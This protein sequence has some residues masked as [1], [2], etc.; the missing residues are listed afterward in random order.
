MTVVK[1]FFQIQVNF[2]I[3]HTRHWPSEN[4]WKFYVCRNKIDFSFI[5]LIAR[6]FANFFLFFF[7]LIRYLQI[8][9][10]FLHETIT[11]SQK[12][13]FF[14]SF[15]IFMAKIY[16][17]YFTVLTKNTMTV[18]QITYNYEDLCF[19]PYL[20]FPQHAF[21]AICGSECMII[22]TKA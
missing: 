2:N 8:L 12:N 1:C 19:F 4:R 16:I 5:N 3:L 21:I 22:I 13:C 14:S 7:F 18:S 15:L 6:Y 17:E 10:G 11:S 9:L 20:E